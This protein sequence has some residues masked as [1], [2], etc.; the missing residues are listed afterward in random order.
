M[1]A[2]RSNEGSLIKVLPWEDGKEVVYHSLFGF[3]SQDAFKERCQN[4]ARHGFKVRNESVRFKFR[5]GGPSEEKFSLQ[6]IENCQLVAN[7]STWTLSEQQTSYQI[8]S[9]KAVDDLPVAHEPEP[10]D[11]SLLYSLLFVLLLPLMFLLLPK[12]GNIKEEPKVIEQV[13]VQI[14]PEVQK[15]VAVIDKMP[16][17][18]KQA[19]V[20]KRAIKQD[21]GFLGLLGRKDLTKAVGGAPTA[22]KDVSAG[23]GA[24]GKQGS[25]GE[26]LVGLGEGLKRVSVGN[27]GVAGLGGIGTKGAGG[28]AGG[29]G[30]SA[31]GSG[32]GRALSAIPLSDDVT[33]EGG[34]D[35]SVVQATIAKYLSQVRACY[36]QGLK[37]NP[38]L[39]G[40]VTMAFE[41]GGAGNLN[42][43]HVDKSSLG[44]GL[45]EEC[46]S[47]RM[48]D[49]KFPQPRGGVNVKI[50]YP[51]L[52]RAAKG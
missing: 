13:M 8:A 3:V 43:A 4:R 20:A 44:D 29:Y 34:L 40:Q 49:W 9:L 32:E 47:K 37:R 25:G 16:E 12:N 28:G 36:E 1:I 22:L 2:I 39:A 23:A 27:T 48:L 52:L 21:L 31:I 26:L 46:I 35:R 41:V 50:S 10:K 45:V 15:P 17:V 30:N 7:G 38:G 14:K 33:L 51:F 5:M 11:R 42:F 18:T 24:G 19:Q 6:S